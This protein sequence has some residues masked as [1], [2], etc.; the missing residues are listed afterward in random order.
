MNALKPIRVVLADDHPV[1]RLGM[2]NVLE[3]EPGIQVVAEACDGQVALEATRTFHP[4]ILVL[5]LA[6]P[7]LS[8]LQVLREMARLQLSIRTVLLTGTLERQV[9]VEAIELGARG[10]VLKDSAP[11]DIRQ[12]VRT[13]FSGHVWFSDVVVNGVVRI[14]QAPGAP[15]AERGNPFGLTAREREIIS[16]IVEGCTN[17]DV[18]AKLLIAEDTVKR[19]VTNIFNKLGMSTRVELAMFAVSH[20]LVS[21]APKQS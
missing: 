4:D 9:L 13:V 18:G 17:K 12:A 5:D 10:V 19:H 21:A 7:R 8:G 14:L 11:Q 3:A 6:M 1:V 2:R 16:A 20:G 15:A